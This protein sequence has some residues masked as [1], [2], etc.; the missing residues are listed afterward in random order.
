MPLSTT[1]K[2]VPQIRTKIE[3]EGAG[4]SVQVTL[5]SAGVWKNLLCIAAET[6]QAAVTVLH[7][8]GSLWAANAM[9]CLAIGRKSI[10]ARRMMSHV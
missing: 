6:G 9:A 3:E 4:V 2:S 5:N 10:A 8:A 7:A 1:M